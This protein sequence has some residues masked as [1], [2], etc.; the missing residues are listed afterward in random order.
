MPRVKLPI[1]GGDLDTNHGNVDEISLNYYPR[2]NEGSG[3]KDKGILVSRPG[4]V[5]QSI[6]GGG[7]ADYVPGDWASIVQLLPKGE[8]V[9]ALTRTDS[10]GGNKLGLYDFEITS[11]GFESTELH[12]GTTMDCNVNI[13]IPKIV[14]ADTHLYI[15]DTSKDA[16]LWDISGASLTQITDADFPT[17]L[18]DIEYAEGYY[19]A[20]PENSDTFYV[21]ALND[22][23]TWDALDF[24]TTSRKPDNL[25]GIIKDRGEIWFFGTQSAEVWYNA[26]AADFPFRRRQGVDITVGLAARNS[27]VKVD[28]SIMWIGRDEGGGVGVYRADGYTPK[29]VSTDAIDAILEERGDLSSLSG[30]AFTYQGQKFYGFGHQL[31][32]FNTTKESYAAIGLEELFHMYIYHVNSGVW[33]RW[34]LEGDQGSIVSA[35]YLKD[36]ELYVACCESGKMFYLDPDVDLDETSDDITRTRTVPY[37]QADNNKVTINS[38][39]LE[40]SYDTLLAGRNIKLT[41]TRDGTDGAELT[42]PL[43][44]PGDNRTGKVRFN[45]LGQ[46][47]DWQFKISTT[48]RTANVDSPFA[49]LGA[50][51]DITV[52]EE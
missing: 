47:R 35:A 12:N 43:P 17:A 11:N 46:A 28:N 18:L 40:F 33:T 36:S 39:I 8:K 52:D 48:D 38:L 6:F 37:F 41:C 1:V 23:S 27:L 14:D 49:F 34:N 16:Y 20:I 50:Y 21:S 42:R 4:I 5:A 25:A 7:A 31:S 26:G 24:A 45:M 19:L 3:G 15:M 51:I 29:K 32:S 22:G 9:Y 30:F 44:A 2:I 10:S 13:R